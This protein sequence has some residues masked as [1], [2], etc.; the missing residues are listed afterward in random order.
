MTFL[1]QALASFVGAFVAFALVGTIG[2]YVATG[3][4]ET[5]LEVVDRLETIVNASSEKIEK[6]FTVVTSGVGQIDDAV[7]GTKTYQRFFGTDE[8]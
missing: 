3:Y 8:K 2:F 7:T 4:I 5:K 1:K 6:I